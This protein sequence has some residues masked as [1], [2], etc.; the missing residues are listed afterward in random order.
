MEQ[1]QALLQSKSLR[2]N[3]MDTAEY[4]LV[5]VYIPVSFMHQTNTTE[6]TPP[7]SSTEPSLLHGLAVFLPVGRLE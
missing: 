1:T 4:S 7:K 5:L 2:T 6:A 3:W